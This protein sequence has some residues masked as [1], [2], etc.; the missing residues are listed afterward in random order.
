MLGS[1]AVVFIDDQTCPVD[2][3][4]NLVEFY[5]HESCSKCTPCREGRPVDAESPPAGSPT[6]SAE[7]VTSSSCATSPM[8]SRASASARWGEYSG[9]GEQLARAGY[10]HWQYW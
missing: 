8:V 10:E 6:D 2:L 4:L 9:S 5:E 7:R 1:G 3:A